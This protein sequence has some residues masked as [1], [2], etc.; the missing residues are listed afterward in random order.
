MVGRWPAA[1]GCG[2]GRENL[3]RFRGLAFL[4]K[5]GVGRDLVVYESEDYALAVRES[6]NYRPGFNEKL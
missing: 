4:V 3:A 5:Y 6:R 1:C 2:G